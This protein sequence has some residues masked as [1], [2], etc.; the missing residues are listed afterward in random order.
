MASIK[1]QGFSGSETPF[2]E[3]TIAGTDSVR[4]LYGLSQGR[5]LVAKASEIFLHSVNET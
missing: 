5:T 4:G 3:F 2:E 1:N